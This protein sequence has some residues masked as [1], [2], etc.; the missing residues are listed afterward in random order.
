MNKPK[1]EKIIVGSTDRISLPEFELTDIPCKIDTGA[2]TSSLHCSQVKILEKNDETFLVFKLY[3]KR[4]GLQNRKEFRFKEFKE[5]K[6]RSSNGELDYRYSIN[7]EVCIFN[8]KIKTEFTLSYREKM[9]FPILLGKRF[10]KNRFL[11]D[12][13]KDELSFNRKKTT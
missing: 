9:K 5:R 12:V 4:F 6:V 13:S 3:D 7:T 2:Y 1:S 10:L 11:V 8:K